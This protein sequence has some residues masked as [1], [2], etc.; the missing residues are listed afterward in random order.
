MILITSHR[1]ENI[2]KPMEN[3]FTAIKDIVEKYEDVEVVFPMHLNP[4]VQKL[5]TKF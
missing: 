2:G 5:Q 1:S 4:K 3:I